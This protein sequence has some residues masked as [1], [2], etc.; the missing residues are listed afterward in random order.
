KPRRTWHFPEEAEEARIE[1]RGS[2][3]D[4]EAKIEQPQSSIDPQSS[5]LDPTSSTLYTRRQIVSAW[6]PWVFLTLFVFL[7]GLPTVKDFLG[8]AGAKFPMPALH[9]QIA[10]DRPVVEIRRFEEAVFDF[11]WLSATGTS[12]FLAA[13]VSAIWLRVS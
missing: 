12:L 6:M 10:R 8:P 2:K 7:W 13:I 11:N 5:I 4:Q 3:I 9:E 1:D